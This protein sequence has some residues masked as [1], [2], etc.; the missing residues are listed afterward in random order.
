MMIFEQLNTKYRLVQTRFNT[1]ILRVAD[2][3]EFI[4]TIKTIEKNSIGRSNA[5]YSVNHIF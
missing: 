5:D 2:M 4:P 3:N 1:V